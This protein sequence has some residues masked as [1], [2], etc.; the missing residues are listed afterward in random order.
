MIRGYKLKDK[1][2]ISLTWDDS[3]P[4]EIR[5][6]PFLTASI[7]R[8]AKDVPIPEPPKAPEEDAR[9]SASMQQIGRALEKVGDDIAKKV[10]KWLKLGKK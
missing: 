5:K 6:E 9:D 10:P 2:L 4:A 1:V 3:V 7:A 8:E